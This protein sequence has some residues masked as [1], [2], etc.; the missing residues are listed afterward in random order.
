[1]AHDVFISHSSKDKTF[2]DA[3]CAT[4]ECKNIRCW[5]APRDVPPG[6]HYGAALDKAIEGSNIFILLI[7]KR[8][9]KSAQVIRELEIAADNGIPIIPI[10]IEDIEPTDAMRYYVKSLHWLDA[11]TPPIERHLEKI[12]ASVQTF[13]SVANEQEILPEAAPILEKPQKKHLPLPLQ[14]SLLIGMVALFVFV[15]WYGLTKLNGGES[16]VQLPELTLEAELASTLSTSD[17]N[18]IPPDWII[19]EFIISGNGLWN[20]EAGRYTAIGL[21]DTIAWSEEK[22]TG[23]IEISLD[24]ETSNSSNDY[25]AAYIIVYGN[26]ITMSSGNL[27][28]NIAND[29]LAIVEGSI[30]DDN[31]YTFLTFSDVNFVGEKHTVL[32]NIIDRKATLFVDGVKIGSVF[33]KDT[34]DTGGKIGLLKYWEIEEIIFS[35]IRIKGSEYP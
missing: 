34:T 11:M 22:Y 31:D 15:G 30:Y 25:A 33:L 6:T 9:N 21:N 24:I 18:S 7:S 29:I 35:N 23:D 19:P 26:G 27:I 1:M 32:I 14:I 3:V 17:S 10:R 16:S 8:S 20:K 2:A 4:L 28:F 13:L 12:T 5:I